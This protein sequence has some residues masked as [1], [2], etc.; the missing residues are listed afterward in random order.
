MVG[1][2]GVRREGLDYYLLDVIRARLEVPDLRHKILQTHRE[3]QADATLIEDTELGRAIAQDLRRAG[4]LR[5][6]LIKPYHE[7]RARLEAQSVR[8]ECGQVHVP[9]EAPWLGVYLGELLAFPTAKHDDQVGATSQAL[10]WLT[11]RQALS[12]PRVRRESMRRDDVIRRDFIR[13][14]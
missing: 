11:A 9:P 13:R 10:D 1:G 5:A 7:K 8:F 4:D 2:R 12:M 3:W 6:I 14:P